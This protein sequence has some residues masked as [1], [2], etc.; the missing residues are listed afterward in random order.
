M[1]YTQFAHPFLGC[2]LLGGLGC[3]TDGSDTAEVDAAPTYS[4]ALTATIESNEGIATFVTPSASPYEVAVDD[5]IGKPWYIAFFDAGAEPGVDIPRHYQWGEVADDLVVE[6][7][8]PPEFANGP[9]DAV[10][11]LYLNEEITEDEKDDDFAPIAIAGDLASFTLA[12]TV[13]DEGD[14]DLHLA[15]LRLKVEDDDA[16][17]QIT[18]RVPSDWDDDDQLLDAFINT[19]LTVP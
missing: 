2:I 17:V 4:L 7:T 15:L 11:V 18:N 8:S 10:F 14:P 5:I 9:H 6:Y 12:E 1:G 19:I 13:V 16:Q 3:S